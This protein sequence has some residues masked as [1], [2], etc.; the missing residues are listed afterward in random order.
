MINRF[1]M[2]TVTDVLWW[3]YFFFE[4]HS[5]H[6]TAAH[7]ITC[8][9][10]FAGS[11][12][13]KF[14]NILTVFT[15]LAGVGFRFTAHNIGFVINGVCLAR[16]GIRFTAHNTRFILNDV[17]T[18]VGARITTDVYR[19]TVT[20]IHTDF[21]C[22][23]FL[24]TAVCLGVMRNGLI[25]Y[26]DGIKLARTD[27]SAV[28]GVGIRFIRTR[29]SGTG[30]GTR[31]AVFALLCVWRFSIFIL[32]FFKF[33]PHALLVCLV[34]NRTRLPHLGPV[35]RS[36]MPWWPVPLIQLTMDPLPL[37]HKQ[38]FYNR[39]PLTQGNQF[40]LDIFSHRKESVTHKGLQNLYNALMIPTVKH[41]LEKKSKSDWWVSARKTSLQ[42]ISNGVT[43]FLH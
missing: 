39:Q 7:V 10:V 23:R 13:S 25:V 16:V 11:C 28:Y 35:P 30:L 29:C 42:C 14:Q 12:M 18:G 20:G 17:I 43:S 33:C 4:F 21:V 2:L 3:A 22:H 8:M 19:Y 38:T 5:L 40:A 27:G 24:F 37:R 41:G 1:V 32:S 15:C 31:T 6:S 36:Q 26:G 9:A 34:D